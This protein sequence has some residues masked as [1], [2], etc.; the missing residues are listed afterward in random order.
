[1]AFFGSSERSVSAVGVVLSRIRHIDI[2]GALKGAQR[3]DERTGGKHCCIALATS[4][5]VSNLIVESVGRAML[6]IINSRSQW[7]CYSFPVGVLNV[8]PL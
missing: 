3:E 1:M 8:L 5:F 4:H 6:W 2:K 7:V